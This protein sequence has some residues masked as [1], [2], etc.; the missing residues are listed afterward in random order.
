M[1][2]DDVIYAT[3]CLL[4]FTAAATEYYSELANFVYQTTY[5][6]TINIQTPVLIFN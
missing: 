4:L 2:R 1:Q 5:I 6:N 3:I